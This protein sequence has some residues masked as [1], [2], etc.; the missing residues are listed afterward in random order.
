MCTDKFTNANTILST[1]P[2][3]GYSS[4]LLLPS[5]CNTLPFFLPVTPLPP[6]PLPVF[7][8]LSSHS[9]SLTYVPIPPNCYPQPLIPTIPRGR[10]AHTP[11]LSDST[12]DFA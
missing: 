2:L 8:Y 1:S 4:I 3:P 7:P 6:S 9:P 12:H 11:V 10:A 5:L